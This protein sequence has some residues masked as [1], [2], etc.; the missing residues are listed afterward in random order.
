MNDTEI[1]RLVDRQR[2]AIIEAR[3][4][5]PL[6]LAATFVKLSGPGWLQGAITLGGGSLSSALYLG[7]L[8]GV[9]LLWLQPVAMFMGVVMLSAIAYVTLSTGERPLAAINRHISPVLGWAWLGAALI[10]NI[11]WAMPQFS[12]A[13][14]ALQQNLAPGV[15]ASAAVGEPGGKLFTGILVLMLCLGVV[16]LYNGGSV[17][18]VRAFEIITKL[19]VGGVVL[20]FL[21]VVVRLA[22]SGGLDVRSIWRGLVPGVQ[23]WYQPSEYLAPLIAAAGAGA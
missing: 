3:R 12:L 9:G 18:G 2:K 20:C 17:R 23:M 15:F 8:A 19:M 13:V 21:G 7:V 22:L 5:G 11:V 10:A 16:S 4:R 1:S 6:A 14:A